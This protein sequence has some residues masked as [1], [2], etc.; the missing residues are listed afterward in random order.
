[1]S[2]DHFLKDALDNNIINQY[3]RLLAEQHI[4]TEQKNNQLERDLS[5]LQ[6][7]QRQHEKAIG[8][9]R[10]ETAQLTAQFNQVC[11]QINQLK[12]RINVTE[13][14]IGD[15]TARS[16]GTALD[17][18][19]GLV[20][21]RYS[22]GQRWENGRVVGKAIKMYSNQA[23][24]AV[25]TFNKEAIGGHADWRLPTADELFGIIEKGK[26]PSINERVFPDTPAYWF[27]SSSQH[28][29]GGMTII[30]FGYNNY[31]QDAVFV[32]LVC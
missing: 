30:K 14:K 32:R 9:Q 27:Q 15:F 7:Q 28:N 16:D 18:R 12:Q 10:E 13:T 20:W 8:Q 1:M 26:M 6:T 4:K 19:T 25:E 17:T 31:E 23:M 24:E 11:I 5:A 3:L 29:D 21:C 2:I 22:I